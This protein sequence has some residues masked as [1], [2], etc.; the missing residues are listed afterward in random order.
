MACACNLLQAW[1]NL[2]AEP[3]S[4]CNWRSCVSLQTKLGQKRVV[5]RRM[6][7]SDKGSSG[8]DEETPGG[9]IVV[10]DSHD[11]PLNADRGKILQEAL[12]AELMPSPKR[13]LSPDNADRNK[14]CRYHQNTGHST[15][16]CQALKDK[17]EELIQAGHLRRFV[18]GPTSG[19]NIKEERPHTSK[20]EGGQSVTETPH[21]KGRPSKR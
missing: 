3:P 19:R 20:G 5:R 11:T 6:T 4:S 8:P 13:A 17:I 14:K 21:E 12:S 16:E 18:Q 7:K 1:T 2:G 9:I 10:P 15:E